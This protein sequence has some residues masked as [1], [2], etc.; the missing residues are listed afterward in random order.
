MRNN[1]R[2]KLLPAHGVQ[3]RRVN[4]AVKHDEVGKKVYNQCVV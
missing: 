2:D 4:E 3:V 1:V